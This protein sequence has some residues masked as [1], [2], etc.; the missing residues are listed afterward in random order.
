MK[1]AVTDA[2]IFI[3]IIH[4]GLH[5]RLFSLGFQVHTSLRVFDELNESQKQLLRKFVDRGDLTINNCDEISSVESVRIVRGLS[6]S[7]KEMIYLA[8][9]LNAMILSGDGLVRKVTGI[10]NIEVH[11]IFWLLDRFIEER[12]ITKKQANKKLKELMV[13]NKRLPSD[14]CNKRLSTWK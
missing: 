8:R 7:D 3:D 13:Y 6:N 11:V 2:N 9:H 5:G 12:F 10:Q 1:V 4:I 14:E